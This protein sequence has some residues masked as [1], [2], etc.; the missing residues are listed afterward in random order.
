MDD[1]ISVDS[2]TQDAIYDS[3]RK[4]IK[5]Y[6]TPDAVSAQDSAGQLSNIVVTNQDEAVYKMQMINVDFQKSADVEFRVN[7]LR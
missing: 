6:F 4:K 1:N 7:D 3:G 5:L 2:F